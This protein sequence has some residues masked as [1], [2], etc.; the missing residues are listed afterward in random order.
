[1][2]GKEFRQALLAE[3]HGWTGPHHGG[4]E[5]RETE[6]A[7]AGKL[8]AEGLRREGWTVRDLAQRRKGDAVKVR[9]ARRLRAE[10]TMTLSWIAKQLHMGAA[11][12]LAN[13][14]RKTK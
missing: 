3:M 11:G 6:E 2:G 14:L 13:R 7:W 9:L 1:L 8:L 10:T 12:S 4:E 5:R